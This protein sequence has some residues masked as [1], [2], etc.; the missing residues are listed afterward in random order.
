MAITVWEENYKMA[1][2]AV[3]V[4]PDIAHSQLLINYV[5]NPYYG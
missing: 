2:I 1:N 3:I 4:M 5:I